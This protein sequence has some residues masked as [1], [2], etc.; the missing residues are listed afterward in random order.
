MRKSGVNLVTS[1]GGGALE[2]AG[3]RILLTADFHLVSQR[4]S[5]SSNMSRFSLLGCIF[6]FLLG[7][8]GHMPSKESS[9]S[10]MSSILRRA[11]DM[12]SRLDGRLK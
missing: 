11:G 5:I 9:D 8:A 4:V 2:F 12:T 7:W 10:D 6:C 3:N 1:V